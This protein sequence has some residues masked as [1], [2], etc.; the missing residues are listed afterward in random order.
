MKLQECLPPVVS[1]GMLEITSENKLLYYLFIP[2]VNKIV[3]LH[4]LF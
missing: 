3:S 1:K 4:F 2:L